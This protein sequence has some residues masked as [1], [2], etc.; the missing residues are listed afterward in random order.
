MAPRMRR[1]VKPVIELME[2]LPTVILGF[3]AGLFLAP[4]VELHI[5]PRLSD[6]TNFADAFIGGPT[7]VFPYRLSTGSSVKKALWCPPRYPI[8]VRPGRFSLGI[9]NRTGQTFNNT[10][11]TLK[12][13]LLTPTVA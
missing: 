8:F 10:G 11:N 9:G 2:A 5:R 12:Y 6:G 13:R 3:F 4:Y 7:H 1:K